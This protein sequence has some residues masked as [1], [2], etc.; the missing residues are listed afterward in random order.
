MN[1]LKL[2][3]R[4]NIGDPPWDYYFL[5]NLDENLYPEYL[6]K[7]YEFKT[8]EKLNLDNP[9]TFNEK[10][11]WIKLYG[12]TPLMCDCT[13]KVKVRDYAAKKIG[14]QYLKPVLQN[15]NSFD[16]INFD[17][18]PDKF[19]IKCNHGSKWQY[20]IK[21]KENILKSPKVI[22]IIKRDITG[23]L[24]QEY[25]C[26]NGFELNY[27]GIEPKILIEPLMRDKVRRNPQEINVYC[28]RGKPK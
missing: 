2:F 1:F 20:I 19:V 4:I 15:C 14:E 3:K 13:D 24:E 28:F 16:E 26:W 27:K 23:W 21:N 10:L 7:I 9:K 6:K 22:G 25:W 18:L 17:N 11:Q 5:L 8:G 12:V